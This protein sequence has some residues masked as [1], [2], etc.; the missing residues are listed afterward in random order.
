MN[1][2]E[3][4]LKMTQRLTLRLQEQQQMQSEGTLSAGTK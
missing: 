2:A 1:C 3:K 4:Y